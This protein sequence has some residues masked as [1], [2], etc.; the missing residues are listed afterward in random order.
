[1]GASDCFGSHTAA[2]HPRE[3]V[4]PL[5]IRLQLPHGDHIAA[6]RPGRLLDQQMVVRERGDLCQV[7]DDEHLVPSTQCLEP[8][9]NLD[10]GFTV[11]DSGI[12]VVG[13][14]QEVR[15]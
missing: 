14:G 9:A 15:P 3:L 5:L 2:H 6:V 7:S 11:T 10:R 4:R 8:Q 1:M 13:K 12:T